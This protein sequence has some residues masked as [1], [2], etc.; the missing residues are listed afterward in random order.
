MARFLEMA[1]PVP[2]GCGECIL[3]L[4][5]AGGAKMRFHLRGVETPDEPE[6]LGRALMI[7]VMPQMQMLVAIESADC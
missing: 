3:E 2:A 6:L 4:E 1:V 5:D 7:L